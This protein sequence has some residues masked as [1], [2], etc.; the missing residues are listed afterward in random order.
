MKYG[1]EQ[2]NSFFPNFG[3]NQRN[4]LITACLTNSSTN[5]LS[6]FLDGKAILLLIIIATLQEEVNL[7]CHLKN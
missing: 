2:L 5:L 3:R 6:I 4:S 1:F 7:N